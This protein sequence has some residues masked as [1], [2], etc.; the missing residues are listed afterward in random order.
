V[1]VGQLSG[2]FRLAAAARI[3][4]RNQPQATAG[5]AMWDGDAG[6]SGTANDT[7]RLE[8]ERLASFR[9]NTD[10]KDGVAATASSASMEALA[11]AL[12]SALRR[13]PSRIWRAMTGAFTQ[14]RPAT[15]HAHPCLVP[16]TICLNQ[17]RTTH[18]NPL[19]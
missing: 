11:P 6:V 13:A 16:T 4:E 5:H 2:P 12:S 19:Q 18:K 15:S 7:A 8:L 1:R 14:A 9:S 3:Y 10:V 17:T